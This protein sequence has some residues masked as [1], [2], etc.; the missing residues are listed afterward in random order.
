MATIIKHPAQ[1]QPSGTMLGGAAYHLKDMASQADDYLTKVRQEAA[2][3]I[4]QA[5]QEAE[6]IRLQAEQ[7]GRQVAQE[8]IENIL[9][10]KV[11]Q[12]MQAL[13]PALDS[14]VTQIKD[15]K[16]QWL[17][18]WET[19]IVKLSTSIAAHII[20]RELKTEPELPLKWIREALQLAA[21]S[22]DVS[23]HLHPNDLE[24]LRGE[25]DRL[26]A[27]FCP[28]AT[29]RIVA[30]P[31]ITAGGCRVETQFGAIDVQL[32][33]QLARVEQELT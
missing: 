14:A 27:L 4:Q 20:R 12:Q 18:H 13:V 33:T 19:S 10:E 11:A 15:S 9:D 26:V 24:T 23:I 6:A 8:A 2:L 3:I 5:R 25:V 31:S 22:A 1:V 29:G 21:G 30:D 7:T 16:Q 17:Q 32:E 28:L